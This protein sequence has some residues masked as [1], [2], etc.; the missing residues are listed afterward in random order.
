MIVHGYKS[1]H[2]HQPHSYLMT[3]YGFI[4]PADHQPMHKVSTSV[5]R[6]GLTLTVKICSKY[7]GL[8]T[9]PF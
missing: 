3:M 5:I 2:K 8:Q 1:L 9:N 4:S 7:D 6:P